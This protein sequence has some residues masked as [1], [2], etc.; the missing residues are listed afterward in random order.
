MKVPTVLILG[1][2]EKGEDYLN[3]FARIKESLVKHIVLTGASRF[4]MLEAASSQG[5]NDITVTSNF[6]VAIKIADM[7]ASIGEDGFR[8]RE[9][10]MLHEVMAM[11]D[12]VV[13]V[14]GGTPC[15]F[16]NMEQMN[17]AGHTI[18]LQCSVGVLTERIMRSQNKRPIVANKS[19]EELMQFVTNHLVE[20]EAFY[21]QVH[22][23]WNADE[24]D[25]DRLQITDYK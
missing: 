20:R 19:Q 5:Y 1:G 7:F 10:N 4:N 14:G 25:L 6:E 17:N 12:V 24:L 18:Y 2:S 13:S 16:D 3:L 22:E 23:V 9:Q 8:R 15:F 11:E 21:K